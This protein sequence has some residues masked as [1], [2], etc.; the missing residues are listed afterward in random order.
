MHNN[1]CSKFYT[2]FLNSLKWWS[3]KNTETEKS[4]SKDLA[5]R[6]AD[7]MFPP[8]EPKIAS[9]DSGV[10]Q[11]V[12][13]EFYLYEEVCCCDETYGTVTCTLLG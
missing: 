11:H 13:S 7:L 3:K 10:F 8:E 9:E 4:I 2:G 5:V 12:M 1:Y 6:V